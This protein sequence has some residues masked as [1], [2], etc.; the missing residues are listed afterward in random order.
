MSYLSAIQCKKC[1]QRYLTD[2]SMY[3]CPKCEGPLDIIYDYDRIATKLN[4]STLEARPMGVW[5]YPELLPLTTDT[6]VN[7][8]EGGTGLVKCEKLGKALGLENLYVKNET[9]NP[10]GSFKDRGMAITISKAVEF[11]AKTIVIASTGNAAI[12]AAAYAAKAELDCYVFVLAETPLAKITQIRIYGSK[13]IA[14]KGSLD[15]AFQLSKDACEKYGWHD[16][17]SSIKVNPWHGEGLKTIAFEIIEQLDWKSPDWVI[18]PVGSGSNLTAN[19]KGFKEFRRVH[20]IDDL[21]RMIGAQPSGIAPLIKTYKQGME[22]DE[23]EPWKERKTI[24]SGIGSLSPPDGDT[25]LIAIRESG[26]VAE[27]VTDEEILQAEIQLARNE[28]IFAE[29]TGAIPVAI[30]KKLLDAGIIDRDD[31]IVLE[32][33]GGG[34]KDLDPL[35]MIFH[36]YP[37]IAP[38]FLEL[39]KVLHS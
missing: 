13:V 4:R 14:V 20:L 29:P 18:V 1:G 12:S 30:A 7:L 35:T 17:T 27:E 5:K 37:V 9:M 33:T 32:I 19:W 31:T 11:G 21:P 8:G 34:L 26:G 24:A 15:D 39:E 3:L 36:E 22:P 38:T 6:K 25:A 23:I 16:V 28:G 2:K 10:T